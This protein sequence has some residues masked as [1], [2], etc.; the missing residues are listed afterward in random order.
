MINAL[1]LL[2]A[3]GSSRS[4]LKESRIVSRRRSSSDEEVEEEDQKVTRKGGLMSKTDLNQYSMKTGKSVRGPINRNAQTGSIS[5][6]Q[7]RTS[8][9]PKDVLQM[10]RQQQLKVIGKARYLFMYAK[11]L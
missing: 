6:G 11:F 8:A 4:L 1:Y 7:F 5:A 2:F 3:Q 9:S 10:Q